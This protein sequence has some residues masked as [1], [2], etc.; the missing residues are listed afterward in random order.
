MKLQKGKQQ[1][2]L[3]FP[4]FYHQMENNKNGTEKFDFL[5]CSLRSMA[6]VEEAGIKLGEMVSGL[7]F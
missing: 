7:R 1:Q 2:Y 4:Y 6:F 5:E 3:I